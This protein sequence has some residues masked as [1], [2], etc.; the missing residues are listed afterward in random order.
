MRGPDASKC[1]HKDLVHNPHLRVL[2][3]RYPAP[4]CCWTGAY[5]KTRT[6]ALWWTG[7]PG[8]TWS[9]SRWA[10]QLRFHVGY[11]T[12]TRHVAIRCRTLWLKQQ[13]MRELQSANVHVA[14]SEAACPCSFQVHYSRPR[15]VSDVI[16][17]MGGVLD[18][19]DVAKICNCIDGRDCPTPA[20]GQ[21]WPVVLNRS[22]VNQQY[23]TWQQDPSMWC[24][25]GRAQRVS[26]GCL[27][28]M[29]S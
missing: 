1:L 17:G 11:Y 21:A 25:G 18:P 4:V 28:C 6:G 10:L 3:C 20:V 13:G 7:W 2:S 23:S 29:G 15:Q 12:S 22:A 27:L 24:Q 19:N 14:S 26:G 5:F 16:P 8:A 9:S